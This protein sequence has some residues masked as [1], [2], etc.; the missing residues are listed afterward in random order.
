MW[1]IFRKQSEHLDVH[2]IVNGCYFLFFAYQVNANKSYYLY[3]A[4]ESDD[5]VSLLKFDGSS[6]EEVNRIEVGIMPT[7]IE[8]PHGIT[9][10]HSVDY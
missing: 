8:G 1:P 2:L 3:V 5:V 7:E 4:A 10:D 9:V 6:I